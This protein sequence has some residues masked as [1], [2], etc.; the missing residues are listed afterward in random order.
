M[1]LLYLLTFCKVVFF[2]K[3]TMY[4]ITLNAAIVLNVLKTIVREKIHLSLFAVR[5]LLSPFSYYLTVFY[6][7]LL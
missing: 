2:F 1:L 6:V 4:S 3:K 7:F 5:V